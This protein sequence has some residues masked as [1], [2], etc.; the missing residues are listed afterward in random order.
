[1]DGYLQFRADRNAD[2][3]L[4][5]FTS[6]IPC[7]EINSNSLE[8]DFERMFLAINL[9]KTKWLIFAGY[10]NMKSNINAFLRNLGPVLDHNMCRFE[11][12]LLTG[13]FNSEITK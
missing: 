3:G 1:M 8:K 11:N 5:S 9:R 7:G 2:R 6:D 12:F 13:D 4:Y 10:N